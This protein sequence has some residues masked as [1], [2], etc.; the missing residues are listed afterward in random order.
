M[1]NQ[2]TKRP[3]RRPQRMVSTILLALLSFPA[4]ADE[5][6]RDVLQCAELT[7]AA[8]RLTCFDRVAG[9][10]QE[11]PA[12]DVTVIDE[13]G[14]AAGREVL[15][16]NEFGRDSL[17]ATRTRDGEPGVEAIEAVVVSVRQRPR[18]EYVFELSNGQSWT[19]SSPGRGRYEPGMAIRIE[20]TTLGAYMLSTPSGRA[21]RVRRLM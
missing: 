12:A 21:T 6:R 19:E 15:P 20:R 1:D 7:E 13:P 3:P 5:L 9:A 18:G 16:H 4:A 8:A 17:P 11:P 2:M 14:V 10:L